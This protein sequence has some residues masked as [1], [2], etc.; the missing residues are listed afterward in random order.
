MWRVCEEGEGGYGSDPLFLLAAAAAAAFGIA[1]VGVGVEAD[2]DEV[3]LG[4]D[5]V[6]GDVLG[7]GRGVGVDCVRKGRGI[8]GDFGQTD[9]FGSGG[10]EWPVEDIGG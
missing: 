8:V 1:E 5:V 6:G 2:A 9:A 3:C 10:G 4:I 7:L